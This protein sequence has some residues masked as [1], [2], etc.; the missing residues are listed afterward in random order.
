MSTETV[1]TSLSCNNFYSNS[2][3]GEELSFLLIIFFHEYFTLESSNGKSIHAYHFRCYPEGPINWP[4]K[5]YD[6]ILREWLLVRPTNSVTSHFSDFDW[7]IQTL[8]QFRVHQNP[9]EDLLKH[10]LLV[11][12]PEFLILWIFG[13]APKC[14]FPTCSQLMSMILVL[15]AYF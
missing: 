10:T 13:G 1:W 4:R 5:H 8:I 2:R 11:P 9:L 3:L 6:V 15:G 12:T 7:W 14:A